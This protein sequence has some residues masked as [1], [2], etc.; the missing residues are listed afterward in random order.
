MLCPKTESIHYFD[1]CFDRER[2][3]AE[4]CEGGENVKAREKL[5]SRETTNVTAEV[6]EN[7]KGR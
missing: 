3:N 6:V 5:C 2:N 7:N 4:I 1:F